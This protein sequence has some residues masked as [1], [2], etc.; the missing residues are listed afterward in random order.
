MSRMAVI[1]RSQAIP[2][3]GRIFL[4]ASRHFVIPWPILPILHV[5]QILRG[6]EPY[7]GLS[8]VKIVQKTGKSL[9]MD[10][11]C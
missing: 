5:G 9:N 7:S 11:M 3:T 4:Q 1:V 10:F 2:A 8:Q 6:V